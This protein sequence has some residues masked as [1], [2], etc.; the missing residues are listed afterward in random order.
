MLGDAGLVA[1]VAGMLIEFVAFAIDDIP[2]R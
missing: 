2:G 1:V